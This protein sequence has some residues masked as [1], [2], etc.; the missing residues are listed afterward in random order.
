MCE[1]ACVREGV[2]VSV[3]VP[4]S[5]PLVLW[6]RFKRRQEEEGCMAADGDADPDGDEAEGG[7]E[8]EETEAEPEAEPEASKLS[9][10][11]SVCSSPGSC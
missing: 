2:Y 11:G 9:M 4:E 8:D 5:L 6:I 3:S 7:T 1:C 10:C